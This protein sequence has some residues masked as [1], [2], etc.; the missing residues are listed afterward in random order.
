MIKK[1]RTLLTKILIIGDLSVIFVAW[2]LAYVLRFYVDFI[3]ATKGIYRF[4]YHMSLTMV[5]LTVW[6]ITLQ[7]AGLYKFKRLISKSRIFFKLFNA[8]VIA[9]LLFI[10]ITYLFQEY[11]FSR[12][13]VGYFFLTAC[14]LLIFFRF[15]FQKCLSV[16]RQRG[17]N[18]RYAL[19]IGHGDLAQA[20][21]NK[22]KNYSETGVK[23]TGFVSLSETDTGPGIVGSVHN[24]EKLIRDLGIDQVIIALDAKDYP[25]LSFILQKLRQE[26][27]DV[28][29]VPEFYRYTSLHYDIEE[30][31]E[32]PFISLNDTRIDA[33][34]FALK[35]SLDI[36]LGTLLFILSLPVM[37]I[38]ALTIRLFSPGPI[39][40][41]Q[42]RIGLDGKKF[43]IYK[44]RTMQVD[45]EMNTGAVWARPNDERR[46]TLGTF[47]RKTSI[48][49]L[50]Q[51]ANI[52][53]G[54][55]SL[56]G[57]RPERP[58]FVE[59]FKEHYPNYMLRHKVKAGLTGWAQVNGW[60]GNTDL[61]KRIEHD[62]YYIKNWSAIF[63]LKI[64]WLTIWRGVFH[65]NAY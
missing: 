30:L 61:Q 22:I 40:Y 35:R 31:D 27:T 21:A 11:R 36:V 28:K 33:W 58:V 37:L 48:D 51:L 52:I 26:T 63:D 45:A 4:T 24:I 50:P 65:K 2:L 47:L 53:L 20:T 15:F 19:I 16:L 23:V 56:V 14:T 3:P 39:F 34:N 18:L 62:L 13:V 6:G 55:M 57:P 9:T 54:H 42:E 29:I 5:V 8:S 46:T 44:F 43:N 41:S 59:K 12:G 32:L 17:F 1:N 64:I 60:R 49:E 10:A 38:T 25:E 7:I